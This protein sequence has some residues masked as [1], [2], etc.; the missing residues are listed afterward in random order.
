LSSSRRTLP[1]L[2]ALVCAAGLLQAA[3]AMAAPA[4]AEPGTVT[5]FGVQQT[6]LTVFESHYG[7]GPGGRPVAAA[8]RSEVGR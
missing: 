8:G 2:A 6:A 4:A 3:P 7:T 5:D 1:A